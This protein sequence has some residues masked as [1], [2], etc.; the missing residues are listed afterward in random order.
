M[1]TT[2]QPD[3]QGSV[4]T[5]CNGL[6]K[7]PTGYPTALYRGSRVHFCTRACRRVFAAD[8]DHFMAG[9]IEHPVEEDPV[10]PETREPGP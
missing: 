2:S 8:P 6:L 3:P 4:R 1:M 9:E 5:V 7:D 10:D